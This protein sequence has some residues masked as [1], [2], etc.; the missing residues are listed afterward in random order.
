MSEHESFLARWS[1]LKQES[2]EPA[3]SEPAQPASEQTTGAARPPGKEDTGESAQQTAS[4]ERAAFDPA[5]LPSLESIARGSDIREF[6]QPGVPADL[7][8]AALRAA[9]VA[10]PA[11]RDFVGIADSQWDFNDPTAMPGFG[12]LEATASGRS[13]TE[14]TVARI[15]MAPGA[16]AEASALATRLPPDHSVLPR[17]GQVDKVWL[18]SGMVDEPP[19]GVATDLPAMERS[20][21]ERRDGMSDVGQEPTAEIQQRPAERRHGSALPKLTR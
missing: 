9:W 13:F 6:L 5:C 4:S 19:P 1:R 12:P 18:S 3:Q 15:N 21:S 11:I 7:L 20:V 10:D 17:E 8:R 2:G 14:Q 16:I